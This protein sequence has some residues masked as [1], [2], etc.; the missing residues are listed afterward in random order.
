MKLFTSVLIL[1]GGL[2]SASVQA[3][4][5]WNGLVIAP[6]NRC[7]PY[8]KKEQYPYPQ[9]VEDI[10]VENM[11]GI[12][13]GPYTGRTFQSDRETDIEHIVSSSDGH[14]SGLCA[15]SPEVR[16]Q[17]ATDP[18][19]LTLAAPKINR[20]SRGGKCGF[21]AGEWMPPVNQCWFAQTVVL[22]KQKYRLTIN[23]REYLSLKNTLDSCTSTDMIY[24]KNGPT[25]S[26]TPM[27]SKNLKPVAVTPASSDALSL[28]DDN[29][30]G[31]ITCSEARSHGIAPVMKSHSAYPYMYDPDKDGVVCE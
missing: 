26:P 2:L 17:F 20:C 24:Y 16:E 14:D 7:S 12:V 18:L 25:Q 8:D 21:D 22:V 15:A 3:Q 13:Y 10:V 6:E 5:T 29:N 23:Q 4:A 27:I 30:N 11:G 31:R 9:S 19:N 1:A 28:Y